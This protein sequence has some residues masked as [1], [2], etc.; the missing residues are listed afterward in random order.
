M[1]S[2]GTTADLSSIINSYLN[3]FLN[4]LGFD[5]EQGRA[6]SPATVQ[7]ALTS[8]VNDACASAQYNGA[9]SCPD[10]TAAINSAVATY[11]SAY[12][13]AQAEFQ[14]NVQ[15]GLISTPLPVSSYSFPTQN[16]P[17]EVPV[18]NGTILTATPI[19]APEPTPTQVKYSSQLPNAL[20]RVVPQSSTVTASP[21]GNVLSPPR[22]NQVQTSNTGQYTGTSTV[23]AN[24]GTSQSTDESSIPT[25]ALLGAAALGLFL[26]M[27]G[28]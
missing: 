22:T 23:S 12:N 8:A 2:L 21:A 7:Q 1:G 18:D 28:R 3:S 17:A 26:M 27:K 11:T 9:T 14:A 10:M 15:A 16:Y 25:W 4:N 20:D 13:K 24:P 6:A 5:I 19:Y